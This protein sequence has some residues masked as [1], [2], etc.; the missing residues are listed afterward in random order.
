MM[1]MARPHRLF[2]KLCNTPEDQAL[3]PLGGGVSLFVAFLHGWDINLDPEPEVGEG[4]GA[5]TFT[6]IY[7]AI[8]SCVMFQL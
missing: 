3:F 7:L 6:Y 2:W 4:E 5:L 8:D 1:P